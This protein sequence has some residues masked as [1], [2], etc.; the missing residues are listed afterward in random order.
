M[1]NTKNTNRRAIDQVTELNGAVG[2]NTVFEG[3]L[4]G[5]GNYKVAGRF[6]GD[7]DLEGAL[8][9]DKNGLWQGNITADIV[10]IAGEVEGNVVANKQLEVSRTGRV[11]GRLTSPV[12]ALENGAEHEGEMHM[13]QSHQFTDRRA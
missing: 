10:V 6:I 4:R 5:K 7:C 11:N 12:I 1:G 9:L 3:Q 13:T 2:S 8:L